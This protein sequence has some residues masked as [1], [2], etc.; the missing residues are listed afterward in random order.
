MSEAAAETPSP[1]SFGEALAAMS[2]EA[3]A[4]LLRQRPDAAVPPPAD[5]DVLASRLSSQ[6]SV[7]RAA[8]N[9]DRFVLQMLEA[10]VLGTA[11]E[12]ELAISAG[13]RLPIARAAAWRS[14]SGSPGATATGGSTRG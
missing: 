6:H 4:A 11:D 13:S 3:L 2:D 5:F 7:S 14:R 12:A 10:L 9:V 1:A 8:E